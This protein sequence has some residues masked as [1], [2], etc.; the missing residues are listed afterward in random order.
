MTPRFRLPLV[1]RPIDE[2]D[3]ASSPLELLFD[4]TFV[5]AIA[6]AVAQLAHGIETGEG[7]AALLPFALTFFAIWWAWMNFTWFSSGYDNDDSLY[8]VTTMVQM[9]G[10]LVL[11]SGIPAAFH[12]GDYATLVFGYFVMRFGL[13]TQWARAAVSDPE[14]R[15]SAVR[16]IVGFG[17]LQAGWVARLFVAEPWGV[18]V[19]LGLVV[20][21]L[22]VPLWAARAGDP[23]WN[24]GHIAER[25]GLFTIILLGESVLAAMTGFQRAVADGLG[26][27]LVLV[28]LSAVVILFALWW[29][30]YLQPSAEGLAR[31]RRFSYVWAYGHYTAFGALAVLGA[32][33]EVAVASTGG[34]GD[35]AARVIASAV[36]LPVAVF[37]VTLWAVNAQLAPQTALRAR[38]ILPAAAVVA[39]LPVAADYLQ[40][41]GVVVGAALV[42]AATVALASA[43]QAARSVVRSSAQG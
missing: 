17:A 42:C 26:V 2:R 33:L 5:V 1:A 14:H 25:F 40:P 34:H 4:L 9:V 24:P 31:R 13:I 43:D 16:T 6:Q 37:L 7:A 15:R 10:V 39:A 35:V 3:R 41:V 22:S 12:D 18:T 20:L 29:L 19:S 23:G 38:V 32:G 27:G 8:R 28:A 11:A 36:T 30:Y 21:E